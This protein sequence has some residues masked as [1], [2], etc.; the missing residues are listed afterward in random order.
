M[1]LTVR[2]AQLGEGTSPVLHDQQ[3]RCRSARQSWAKTV[4]A[5]RKLGM[6]SGRCLV[7]SHLN[8]SRAISYLA[9]TPARS[10]NRADSE[11]R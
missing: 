11:L 3:S 2:L 5:A 7:D 6:L 9:R 10:T 8:E 4:A 1:W